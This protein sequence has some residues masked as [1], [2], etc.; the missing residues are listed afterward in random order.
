VG[1]VITFRD[2]TAR[3]VEEEELRHQHK[4]EAVG[5]LAAG[6]A[7]DF[8]NLLFLILGYTEEMM[9]THVEVCGTLCKRDSHIH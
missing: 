6:I 3:Q 9:R 4:M 5:R 2:A 7:H 8:N 1:A